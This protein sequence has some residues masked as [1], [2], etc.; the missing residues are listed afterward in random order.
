[1]ENILRKGN[2]G[3][4]ILALI[5][6]ASVFV[7]AGD[8]V[9]KEGVIEGEKFKS[10]GCTATGTRAVALGYET[11]ASGEYSTATGSHTKASGTGSTAM[12][13]GSLVWTRASG[14][15]STAIGVMAIATGDYSTAIGHSLRAG[16]A[17]W[18]TAIGR[19]FTND[20]EESFAVGFGR[21]DFSVVNGLVTVYEDLY[22]TDDVSAHT[23]SEH[24]TFYDKDT[25]GTALDYTEDSSKTIK[26]NAVGQKEYDHDADPGFLQKW[27]TVKDYDKYTEEE[28][29]DEALERNITRRTYQTHQELRSNLS[30]KLAWLRQCVFELKQENQTLKDE[31]AQ[32]KTAVGIE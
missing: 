19:S 10:T 11:E 18:T 27:V 16:P 21:K 31:I 22:V 5:L 17:H 29:W 3:K 8:V 9:V 24:S 32:I 15:A 2:L 7:F 14:Y 4:Y 20:A 25:Y 6:F 30:M 12:G 13:L 1:M 26:I 28:V 23:Y